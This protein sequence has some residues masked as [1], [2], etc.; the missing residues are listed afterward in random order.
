MANPEHLCRYLIKKIRKSKSLEWICNAI[1]II[2]EIAIQSA[3]DGHIKTCKLI[4]D[5]YLEL[6]KIIAKKYRNEKEW[7][8]EPLNHP[9]RVLPESLGRIGE[10]FARSKIEEAIPS[11]IFKYESM[12]ELYSQNNLAADV[13]FSMSIERIIYECANNKLEWT[14]FNFLANFGYVIEY[15][16]QKKIRG[17]IRAHGYRSPGYM[18]CTSLSDIIET[19]KVNRLYYALHETSIVIHRITKIY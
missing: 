5:L 10:N 6:S 8:A 7:V 3:R 14:I 19:L 16:S 11:I 9:T 17:V 12:A 2:E 15:L 1:F 18:F 13:E 4:T